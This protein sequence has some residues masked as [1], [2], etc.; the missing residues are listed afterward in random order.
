MLFG[1]WLETRS[2]QVLA[3]AARACWHVMGGA[4]AACCCATKDDGVEVTAYSVSAN[5]DAIQDD[6]FLEATQKKYKICI[7][8]KEQNDQLGMDVKH[9]LG[10]LV[11]LAIRRGGAVDRANI[12]AKQQ[13]LPAIQVN[14]VIVEVNGATLDIGMVAACK[15][16]LV[17]NV[18]FIRREHN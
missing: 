8:K 3:A 2:A 16:A 4:A 6:R 11:V 10:R 12:M 1:S 5:D 14:D 17:L 13:N 7:Q 9:R 18:T 15:S